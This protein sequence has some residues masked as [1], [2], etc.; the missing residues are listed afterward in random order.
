MKVNLNDYPDPTRN[1]I[2]NAGTHTVVIV[3]AD[4]TF[5]KAR[6]TPGL[7]LTLQDALG[8]TMRDTFYTSAAAMP[9]LKILA[10]ACGLDFDTFDSDDCIGKTVEIDVVLDDE[11]YAK[12]TFKG[13]R[14]TDAEVL[15][16]DM[17]F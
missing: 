6:N 1:Y 3:K 5:S 15:P 12:T 17:P 13:Y 7:T 14:K 2:D 9:R 10:D 16:M 11:N 4:E 8:R